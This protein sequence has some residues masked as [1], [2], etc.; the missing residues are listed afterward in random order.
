MTSPPEYARWRSA[1]SYDEVSYGI[2][3]IRLVPLAE[4]NEFQLGYSRLPSGRSLRGG[5]GGWQKEWI[6][7]GHETAMGDPVILDVATMR[8][9]TAPHGEGT[10]DPQPIATS[11]EGFGAALQIFR[12][13]AAGRGSPVQLE[14]H[15]LSDEERVAALARIARANPGMDAFFWELLLG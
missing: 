4:L 3:G 15:P 10:W 7:I 8:V 13:V 14:A 1:L 12:D 2:G 5:D 11:L 6:A 9:M